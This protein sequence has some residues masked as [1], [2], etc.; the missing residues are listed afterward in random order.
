VKELSLGPK[1][2]PA[3]VKAHRFIELDSLRGIAASAVVFGHFFDLWSATRWHLWTER[4]P[5][6]VLFAGHEAVVLFFMLSGF[7][8]SIPLSSER[9]PSYRVFLM[10]RFCR[11]YLPYVAAILAA[12]AC[13]FF[14]YSTTRTGDSWI[15]Q[16]WSKRPTLELVL[17]HLFTVTWYPAQLNTAIWT[18]IVEI[19]VSLIFPVLFWVVRRVRPVLLLG[20]CAA[21]SAGLPVLPHGNSL[22][23]L[24]ISPTY[25]ALFAGGILLWLHLPA[26]SHFLVGMG[27]KGR[28][29]V[30]LLSLLCVIA[31]HG[32]D[33]WRVAPASRSIFD[34]DDYVIGV[35][36]AGLIAC[37][38]QAG[39]LRSM[40]NHPFLVRLGALSYSTYLMH[41]T[42]IFVLIRLYYGRF[43]F[44]YLLP[45]YLV[46]VYVVS[47]LFHKFVDQPSVML[48]RRVGK[49]RKQGEQTPS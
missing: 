14:L 3:E 16:T 47:E 32:L 11:I 43:P 33:A 7:V 39:T 49:R 10:R 46:G 29:I 18:L 17:G 20:V 27:G 8:L 2:V 12:A 26:V 40:L 37:A 36:A 45:V 28:G 31:P 24:T 15:D 21:L 22:E 41:P 1:I 35:G 44:Y 9:A 38:I 4:S 23:G 6:R 13:D 25:L 34:L 48:G 19:R 5:L 30:L 42:V